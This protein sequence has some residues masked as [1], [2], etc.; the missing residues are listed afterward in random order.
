MKLPLAGRG[1]SDR[2]GNRLSAT[3]LYANNSVLA[4]EK[5]HEKSLVKFENST[6]DIQRR[7]GQLASP[8]KILAPLEGL[9]EVTDRIN[10]L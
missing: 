6:V 4:I 5:N 10:V 7:R 2:S 9:C 8:S 1:Q 3:Q